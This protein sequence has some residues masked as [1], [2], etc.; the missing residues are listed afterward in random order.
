[1]ISFLAT[2]GDG[3][4]KP[5]AVLLRAALDP[6]PLRTG[7]G[8]NGDCSYRRQARLEESL[9]QVAQEITRRNIDVQPT[10]R[11]AGGSIR[12]N[13]PW[14]Q[15][16]EIRW[17]LSRETGG[18]NG[19]KSCIRW[20]RGSIN[21]REAAMTGRSTARMAWSDSD[22]VCV[23][24]AIAA[25]KGHPAIAEAIIEMTDLNAAEMCDWL[26]ER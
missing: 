14:V 2:S 24:G 13:R 12:G 8:S 25:V 1:M 23:L 15:Y 5:I 20:L 19:R 3:N 7:N 21:W 16:Q 6:S 18:S 9:N 10:L 22:L 17:V 26:R 4:E 11:N